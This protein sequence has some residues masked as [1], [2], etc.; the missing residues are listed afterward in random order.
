MRNSRRSRLVLTILLLAAFSLITIDYRSSSLNGVRSAAATIF[1]PIENGVSDV[2]DPVGSWFSSIGHL[3]SYKSENDALRRRVAELEG[4]LHLTAAE[5]EELTQDQQILKI[6]GIAQFTVVAAR[7]TSYG[8]SFG[9]DETATIDRGSRDG[10]K[11]YETVI[12]GNGLVG[13]TI[14]V[15]RT[16]STIL[17]ANDPTFNVGA[18]LEGNQPE[19]GLVS[20]NGR[21]QPLSLKL[22]SN[23]VPLT[24]G[25]GVVTEGDPQNHDKPFV[26]EVP[27]GTILSINRLGG[28]LAETATVKPFVDYTAVDMV[29]VVIHAPPTI[30]HDSLL[31]ASPSPAPTVTV[32]KTVRPRHTPTGTPGSTGT[33]G[34]AT[35]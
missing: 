14:N 27:I 34:T 32:T 30:K 29:A 12:N 35:P 23:S 5:R 2:T 21:N 22:F 28:G 33:T 10:I 3:G 24:P 6:A 16:T 1:G 13:R 26:P 4:Q 18:R 11:P 8:G 31:P 17:L 20:G 15:G 19:L 7:V 9:F 25:E